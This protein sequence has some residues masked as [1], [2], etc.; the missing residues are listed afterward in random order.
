MASMELGALAAT[1][2]MLVPL[3]QKEAPVRLAAAGPEVA[4]VI[5]RYGIR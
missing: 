5:V 2:G 4:M 3:G 1:K